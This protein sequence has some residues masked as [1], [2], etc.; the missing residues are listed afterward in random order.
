MTRLFNPIPIMPAKGRHSS[1]MIASTRRSYP[2]LPSISAR[3]LGSTDPSYP[4]HSCRSVAAPCL[5]R[6]CI[7]SHDE[8]RLPRRDRALNDLRGQRY[9][10]LP[11]TSFAKR[12]TPR[13]RRTDLDV[14]A[15][16]ITALSRPSRTRHTIET[17]CATWPSCLGAT[18]NDPPLGA[19]DQLVCQGHPRHRPTRKPSLPEPPLPLKRSAEHGFPGNASP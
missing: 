6:G 4:K 12:A 8:T 9:P 5:P 11:R 1:P 15:L 10:Q 7:S 2:R 13:H 3:R 17:R 19:N 14:A 18:R 16:P